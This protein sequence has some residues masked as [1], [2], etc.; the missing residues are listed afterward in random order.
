MQTAYV[1]LRALAGALSL[2]L[3]LVIGGQAKAVT[4][5]II[6]DAES[7][8]VLQSKNADA[9]KYPASLT[10]IMTLYL[11]FEALQQGKIKLNDRFTVSKVAAAKPPTKLGL[12]AGETIRVEDAILGLVTKSANDAA[13]VVAENL[14]GSETRFAELMT[15]KAWALGMKQTRFRNASGLPD[16]AQVT[17]ARDMA[18][19]A[20]AVMQDVPGYYPYFSRESFTFRG[21]T[22]R[23]HNRLLGHYE[24]TDGIKTGYI[25]A[26]GFNLI[27]STK[28]GGTRLVGVVLG[29]KTARSRDVA[30]E[31]LLDRTF[32]E[33]DRAAETTMAAAG[34][35]STSSAEASTLGLISSANAAERV[36]VP[37]KTAVWAVQVGAYRNHRAAERRGNAAADLI[38]GV[39]ADTDVSIQST[40]DRKGD[41]YRA[42]IVGL[43]RKEAADACKLLKRKGFGCMIVPPA[44][45]DAVAGGN[46]SRG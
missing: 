22:H 13:A 21:H 45:A 26:S 19:L 39:L 24:G 10:K 31:K 41:V 2:G 3:A 34:M 15:Q 42:R 1:R 18:K 7:G 23:N 28:R 5:A 6:M 25:R 32:A 27:A 46:T 40:R 33:V 12:R 44:K 36:A 16:K 37:A 17:T 14:A 8:Q 38:P 43:E 29:G 20:R 4:A 11:T 35:P 9:V 30:M